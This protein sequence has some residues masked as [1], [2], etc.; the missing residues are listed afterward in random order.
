M[1]NYLKKL[2]ALSD[3]GAKDLLNASALTVLINIMI[4]AISSISFY[5]I[6]D[7]LLPVLEG[8][9][10]VYTV[11]TYVGFSIMF[12]ILL[13]LAYYF[14]YNSSYVGAYDE[15]ANMRVSLAESLRKLPLSFFGKKDLSDLTTTILSDVTS[16]ETAFSHFI[17]SFLGSIISTLVVGL[18]L[19]AF[20]VRLAL[21]LT[22][23]IP[24]SFLLCFLSKKL[25]DL[26]VI[27][28]KNIMLSCLNKIQECIE[29]VKDIKANNRTQK[30]LN[31]VDSRLAVYEK[32]LVKA[33]F[34]AGLFVTL[35]QMI[36]KLGIATTMLVG[37]SLLAGGEISLLTFLAFLMVA[38]RIYDPLAG[39]LINLVAIFMSLKSVERMKEFQST[40]IQKGDDELTPKG[41]DINFN[42]V[43]FAY[44]TSETV[45]NGVSF[46]AK[47]G[48]ITALVG[49]SGGGKS[50]AMKLAARFWD[51][52][53]GNI[54]IG[55]QDVCSV[56]PEMLLKDISIV[57]QDVTLFNN[58][59]MENIR[60]GRKGASDEDVI[61]A[62]KE[63]RC[64]E[65]I[66]RLPEGYNTLIGENGS[67]LSGGERQRLS[68]ARALL[69]DA[70]IVLL[71]EA[72]S[73][74]DIKSESAVQ[75]AISRLIKQKTV[76]V[77]AHR[78]R[79]IAGANKIVML[80]DGKVS[81]MGTHGELIKASPQYSRMISLQ[82]DSM[83]WVLS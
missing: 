83:N 18:G 45:L 54:T 9:P 60:I 58:T 24:L 14:Q 66:E 28:T 39:A 59:V 50:T 70:P 8:E 81:A 33:E 34:I 32:T 27:K 46:T 72:T 22:W 20:D 30:H 4:M 37:V 38:S 15:S 73:S 29:N 82:N 80:K 40:K 55:G 63:A 71:D 35:S 47:Q 5:F 69:K 12:F 17:P 76:I 79:T 2:F 61:T 10:P 11:L 26:Y 78:M 53:S 75:Q 64:H 52:N 23:V 1:K 3:G 36:L 16:M 48:E 19:F 25:Q 13:L 62:A 67:N 7:T 74:L 56:D 65:F 21:A 49:P 44:D 57:F 68:I 77:I 42:N 43:N 51:V 31:E 41:Y 6:R